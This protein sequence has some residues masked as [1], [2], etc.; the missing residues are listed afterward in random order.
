MRAHSAFA[1]AA[2][3]LDA[4]GRE[5]TERARL[6]EKTIGNAKCWCSPP[7]L[8]LWDDDA[9]PYAGALMMMV[10]VVFVKVAKRRLWRFVVVGVVVSSVVVGGRR[11]AVGV[12][13][14][15]L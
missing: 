11:G 12:S 1:A 9:I 7:P 4:F 5:K 10:V 3:L 14:W 8:R 2:F 15:T 13:R 6:S